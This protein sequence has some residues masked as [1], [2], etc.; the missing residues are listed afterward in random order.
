MFDLDRIR[1][2]RRHIGIQ[3]SDWQLS[4]LENAKLNS[5]LWNNRNI[6]DIQSSIRNVH[7]SPPIEH[8]K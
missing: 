4:Q 3:P 1:Y 6:Y 7:V 8:Y 2:F 5:S